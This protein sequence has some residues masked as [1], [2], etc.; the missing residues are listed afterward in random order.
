LSLAKKISLSERL[1]LQFRGEFFNL[2][3][4]TNLNTPNPVVF[5]SGPTA[6]SPAP[7]APV[8]SATAGVITAT[9]TASR[10][11]QFGLKFLW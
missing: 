4:R 7:M 1:S 5:T 2:L 9:S 6:P 10:Q 3:N 8:P 11:V